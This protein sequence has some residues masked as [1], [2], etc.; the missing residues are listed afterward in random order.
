[1]HTK[2]KTA[3]HNK[4]HNTRAVAIVTGYPGAYSIL[5]AGQVKRLERKLCGVKGCKCGGFWFAVSGQ[6]WTFDQAGNAIKPNKW[7]E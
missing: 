4:F 2:T 5:N 3:F 1:M 6:G 7:L